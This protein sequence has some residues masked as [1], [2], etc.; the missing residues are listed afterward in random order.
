MEKQQIIEQVLKKK[1]I[2]IMRG[3]TREQLIKTVE[4]VTFDQS[5]KIPDEVTAENIRTLTDAFEGRVLVG[6][7]TVMSTEQ[8]EL[9]YKAARASSPPS[10]C[11]R[12]ASSWARRR[13][14]SPA[15]RM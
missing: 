9:A 8:V 15:R 2:V 10:A 6:A 1:I 5:G 4:E 14:S 7:G 13:M 3:M 11:A 12:G